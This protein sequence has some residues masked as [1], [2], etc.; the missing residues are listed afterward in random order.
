MF[1]ALRPLLTKLDLLGGRWYQS[2]NDGLDGNNGATESTYHP[3]LFS[4]LEP[5]HVAPSQLC[6]DP[7]FCC[8]GFLLTARAG[9]LQEWH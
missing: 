6:V 1:E 7:K 9:A 5:F 8:S 3:A 2:A 4:P